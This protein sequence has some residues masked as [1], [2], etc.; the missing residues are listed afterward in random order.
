MWME[1]EYDAMVFPFTGYGKNGLC[2]N[3]INKC[4]LV[5]T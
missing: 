4:K 5:Y 2:N 1:R 3:E